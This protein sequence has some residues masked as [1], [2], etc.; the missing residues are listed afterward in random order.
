M[1]KDARPA[2]QQEEAFEQLYARLEE[3][4]GKLEQG[5]LPL[6]DAIALY[7]KGMALARECQKR[8]DAAEQRIAKL[9]ESFAPIGRTNGAMLAEAPEDYE[10]VNEDDAIEEP[11]EDSS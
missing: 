5:G 7:E 3:T 4:V 11:A 6:D 9:R 10:Y 8:L 2:K 1:A